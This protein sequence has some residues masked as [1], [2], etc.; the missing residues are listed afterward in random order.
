MKTAQERQQEQKK[1]KLDVMEQQIKAGK[2]VVRKM[3]PE[4]RAKFPP[5]EG[6]GDGPRR[7]RKR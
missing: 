4:E 5:R 2:L 3:T 6:A 7:S 1:A